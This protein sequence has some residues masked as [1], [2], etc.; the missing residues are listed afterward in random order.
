MMAQ[1]FVSSLYIYKHIHAHAHTNARMHAHSCTHTHSHTP[2]H[3]QMG[4][5]PKTQLWI[6]LGCE[7][8]ES[9]PAGYREL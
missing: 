7:P 6:S 4:S 1:I 5:F 3:K 8:Q 2:P 9:V